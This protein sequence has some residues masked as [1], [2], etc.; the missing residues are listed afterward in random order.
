MDQLFVNFATPD[1]TT[2]YAGTLI[3]TQLVLNLQKWN[4][5]SIPPAGTFFPSTSVV[6]VVYHKILWRLDYVWDLKKINTMNFITESTTGNCHH[7]Y[8]RIYL[9]LSELHVANFFYIYF[10]IK[11]SNS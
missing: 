2:Q 1:T 7:L 11:K 10:E 8:R 6:S 5:I 3:C 9:S 4:Q